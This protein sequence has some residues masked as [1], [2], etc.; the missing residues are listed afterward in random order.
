MSRFV[1]VSSPLF[2]KEGEEEMR[3]RSGERRGAGNFVFRF[4]F[5]VHR[6]GGWTEM[7]KNNSFVFF[8]SEGGTSGSN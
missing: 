8:S 1:F 7:N 3:G 6:T 4:L 2:E 5:F